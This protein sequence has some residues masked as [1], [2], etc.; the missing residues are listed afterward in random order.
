M[1][2]AELHKA[3]RFHAPTV[4]GNKTGLQITF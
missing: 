3:G 4:S 2:E 1:A